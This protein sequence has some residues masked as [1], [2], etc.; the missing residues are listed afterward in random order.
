MNTEMR[1]GQNFMT[2]NIILGIII[3]L[4]VTNIL[5]T[6]FT[7]KTLQFE[8]Y[9]EVNPV[10]DYI[11]TNYNFLVFLLFKMIPLFYLWVIRDVI[12]VS[13]ITTLYLVAC[14]FVY[15]NVTQ[16]IMIMNPIVV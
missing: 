4:I 13:F 5:D 2:Q 8:G 10:A 6:I 16:I 3:I 7:Q 9:T 12:R 1:C 15:L 11:I 14:G